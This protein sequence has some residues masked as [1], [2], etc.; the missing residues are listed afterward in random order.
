MVKQMLMK[1][2]GPA[3]A[4]FRISEIEIFY[5]GT[6]IPNRRLM[7]AFADADIVRLSWR[8]RDRLGRSLTLRGIRER[9]TFHSIPHST[10]RLTSTAID[11]KMV[12]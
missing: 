3:Y 7:I 11:I 1:K 5:K 6:E 8:L 10:S 12:S 9:G 2:L 4:A